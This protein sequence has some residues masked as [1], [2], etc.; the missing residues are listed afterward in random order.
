MRAPSFLASHSLIL[1]ISFALK[2]VP[3]ASARTDGS[4]PSLPLSDIGRRG[5][6][7]APRSFEAA[8]YLVD[9]ADLVPAKRSHRSFGVP[10]GA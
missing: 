3:E 1:G 8:S 7:F 6:N 5:S 9:H 10:F 4:F 2:Y